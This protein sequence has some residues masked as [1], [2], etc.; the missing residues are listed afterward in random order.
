MYYRFKTAAADGLSITDLDVADGE[1][2]SLSLKHHEANVELTVDSKQVSE[3]FS[4][5]PH[6]F[7]GSDIRRWSLGGFTTQPP[8]LDLQKFNGCMEDLNIDGIKL[9]LEGPN[10]FATLVTVGDQI[11]EGCPGSNLCVTNP[12]KDFSEKPY[13]FLEWEKY[14]CISDAPCKPNRCENDGTCLPQKDGSFKCNCL[15]NFTGDLC[16]IVPAC[17]GNPC[18]D[19]EVC[20]GMGSAGYQCRSAGGDSGGL[21]AG[22]IAAIV[23]FVVLIIILIIVILVVRRH[24]RNQRMSKATPE[25][26]GV[27]AAADAQD[28][29]QRT[30]PSHSSDDS[31]VEIKNPSQ[32]SLTDLQSSS[33]DLSKGVVMHKVGAPENYQIKLTKSNERID[34]GYSESDLGEIVMRNKYNSERRAVNG[35]KNYRAPPH[36]SI[37]TS[38][39]NIVQRTPNYR[40]GKARK[41]PNPHF[42]HGRQPQQL[43]RTVLDPRRKAPNQVAQKSHGQ[44]PPAG[45]LSSDEMQD[46]TDTGHCSDFENNSEMI[47]HYDIDVASIGFS[48][49]S[50]QYDPNQFKDPAIHGELPG[51]SPAEIERLRMRAPSGSMLDAVS[52]A[53]SDNVGPAFDKLSSI[54]EPPDS[55]SES[56]DD[57]F[58]CSEFDCEDNDEVRVVTPS[59]HVSREEQN[60]GSMVFS[61]LPHRENKGYQSDENSPRA[62]LSSVSDEE[63]V[64]QTLNGSAE[65]FNWDDL[66]NWGLR[67]HNLRGVYKDIAQLKNAQ[68]PSNG[69]YEV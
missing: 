48:E 6:N 62:S 66:L 57:T 25:F 2:H 31:G 10:R 46:F 11:A 32:K 55:T 56:S 5:S 43:S 29:S 68:L 23:F 69:E 24:R 17:R 60:R 67:Y 40:P 54:L 65:L 64:P 53:T 59:R 27:E 28:V 26:E 21:S 36:R 61:K 15:A 45:S 7:L 13:C 51:L 3:D 39:D 18:G 50:Y 9:S 44:R 58:T 47:E 30:S 20:E 19:G 33:K 35:P 42:K 14:T 37:P 12:C 22:I 1:W 38:L 4:A 41:L 63:L 8:G 16:E 52:L 49:I 34:R